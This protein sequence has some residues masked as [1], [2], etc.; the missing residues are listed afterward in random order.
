[1]TKW[2]FILSSLLF[3]VS[4]AKAVTYQDPINPKSTFTVTAQTVILVD[5]ERPAKRC[6]ESDSY[7]CIKSH[8]FSLAIPKSR[9]SEW[10]FEGS[11]YKVVS[12]KEQGIFGKAYNY[13]VIKVSGALNFHLLYSR[14]DGVIA[15]REP[16]GNTLLPNEK[17]GIL[18]LDV[19]EGC[20]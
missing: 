4:C 10:S 14:K 15:I 7:V 16:S 8:S 3:F 19:S 18:I 12:K 2:R 20:N 11:R 17:C 9:R 1:M 13:E 6:V 5:V